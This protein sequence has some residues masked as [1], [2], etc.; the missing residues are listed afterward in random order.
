ML[1]PDERRRQ[2]IDAEIEA[3][4]QARIDHLVARGLSP[5][6]A[7]AEALRRFG[8]VDAGRAALVTVART[9]GRRRRLID[10]LDAIRQDVRY[11]CRS[12]ARRPAFTLGVVLTLALGLGINSAVFRV[13]DRV[14]FRAP[15]GVDRPHEVRRVESTVTGVVTTEALRR[16]MTFSWPEARAIIAAAGFATASTSSPP[17]LVPAATGREV[18]VVYADEAYFP[19]L[20][21]RPAIGRFFDADEAQPGADLAVAVVS[22]AFWHREL[23]AAPLDERAFITLGSRSYAVIGVAPRGFVGLDLDPIDVWLPIGV[24]AFGRG[25]INGVP[26]Q[27]Y[28]T[29]MTR[30]LRVVGRLG[31]IPETVVEERLGAALA[32]VEGAPPREASALRAEP[33][34]P[35]GG[36]SISETSRAL[37]GRLGIVAAV[38]FLIACANAM[39]LLLARGIG[40]HREIAT[41]LAL[42]AS[43]ARLWRL[44]L[45]ESVALALLGGMAAAIAGTWSATA[46]QR[47]VVPDGRWTLAVVDAR[48]LVYIVVM[49]VIAGLVAGLAPATQST[50][51]NLIAAIKSGQPGRPRHARFTRGALLVAQ[52]ALSMTMLVAAGLLLL[53][54]LRLNTLPLGFDPQGLVTVSLPSRLFGAPSGGAEADGHLIASRL[55]SEAAGLQV[56]LASIA[57]FGAVR[58]SSL[59]VPGSTFTP[60]D[61]D[62]PRLMDVSANFF[63]VMR[64]T[65]RW[66]RSFT[67][68]DVSGEPVAIVNRSMARNYWGDT[69]PAGA[70][71]LPVGSPCARVIGIV[72]DVIEAPGSSQPAPMRYYLPLDPRYVEA[73]TLVIRTEP[74]AESE[75]GA[76]VR[77][78]LPPTTR[79]TVDVIATRVG[80]AVSP[81]RSAT[82][83][84]VALGAVA[85]VLTCVGLYSIVHH[86]AS[87]RA[88]EFGVRVALGAT[89]RDL[90]ALVLRGG[91]RL[92]IVGGLLGLAGAAAGGRLLAAL[93]F[94]V[95]PFDP[96]IYIAAFAAL[97][98][99]GVGAMLPPARRA[100]RADA[101]VTLRDH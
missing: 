91:V 33:I 94:D 77:A 53:S 35:V 93:L 7:R 64:T 71:V 96:R 25:T 8:D 81:W 26:V 2:E 18:G 49:A 47:L 17:R 41:R 12:L 5:D 32:R 76:R 101:V 46:L 90:T 39:H 58:T 99:V 37:I 80:R 72:D 42:G 74:G 92:T 19:M 57:P 61:R 3:H 44:F 16:Q 38:V 65:V 69:L 20:G 34:V 45:I 29:T 84:F 14:L 30:P 59:V 11:V 15:D 1:P 66:G 79:L 82:L 97:V 85:L 87:E 78:M 83:L 68:D 88:H 73:S 27:W 75:A 100:A 28:Q 50:S 54:L 62:Q 24:G 52:T 36:S 60:D 98:A 63:S 6:A 48:A 43:R 95:S 56:A 51:R 67:A 13:A 4:L 86:S 10:R 22:F 89:T 23:A 9:E 55:S 31:A 70:C 21:V 40:R